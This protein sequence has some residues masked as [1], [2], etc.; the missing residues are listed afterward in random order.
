MR[1]PS[2]S[3][4]REARSKKGKP[5]VERGEMKSE[6]AAWATF[7]LLASRFLPAVRL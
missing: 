6:K 4:K 5:R 2:G 7:S 3:K 1:D